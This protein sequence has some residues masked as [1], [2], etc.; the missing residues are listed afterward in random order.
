[1]AVQRVWLIRHGQTDW[2]LEHR[3]QGFAP[4]AL[5]ATGHQ[6]AQ[7]LA[8]Y[9]Q[10]QATRFEAVYTSDT[11][12]AAETAGYV[13]AASNLTAVPDERLRE[14]DVGKFEG[15]THTE[16][17]AKHKDEFTAWMETDDLTI[18]AP[19]G[20]SRQAV[21]ERMLAAFN[22]FV[23]RPHEQI[24]MVSHGGSI[25]FLLRGLL[26]WTEGHP[27]PNTS[28]SVVERTPNG[29]QLREVGI[30]PHLTDDAPPQTAL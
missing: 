2:N 16:L 23:A 11:P 21:L 3:W 17:L 30:T 7:K 13:A 6:E 24:A 25:R 15:L 20:E 12:R 10:S 5:N 8:A 29:W 27:L 18:P 1:L 28:F 9:L 4:T 26:N 19:E 14:I 22:E